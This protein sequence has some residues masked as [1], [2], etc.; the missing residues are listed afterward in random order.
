ME[1]RTGHFRFSAEELFAEV[2]TVVDNVKEYPQGAV[3]SY[4]HLW[5]DLYCDYRDLDTADSPDE[6]IRL[7][8]SEVVYGVMLLIGF[9]LADQGRPGAHQTH[10][11]FQNIEELRELVNTGAADKLAD[12]GFPG[13]VGQDFVADDPGVKVQLEHQGAAMAVQS[14]Q[15]LFPLLRVHVHAAELVHLKPLAVLADSL[16]SKENGTG[17]TDVNGR[18]HKNHQHTADQAA[19]QAAGNVHG[20]LQEGLLGGGIVH[21]AGEHCVIAH[22]LHDLDSALHMGDLHQTQVHRH[23]H[24]HEI[25][26][27]GL[28]HVA[29]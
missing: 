8:A 26:H 24:F 27:Q 4:D 28:D 18:C 1:K 9:K 6:E 7:A 3:D 14:Q 19:C 23:A 2:M 22:L 16:L 5:D 29:E 13:A 21:A 12:A 15:F 20:T 25:I 10:I 17:R 11:S